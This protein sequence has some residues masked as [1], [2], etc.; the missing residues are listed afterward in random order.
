MRDDESDDAALD[1]VLL[2]RALEPELEV[3]P[4][5]AGHLHAEDARAAAAGSARLAALGELAGQLADPGRGVD[6]LPEV[7]ARRNLGQ[8]ELDR[9]GPGSDLASRTLACHIV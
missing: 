3:V 7:A 5:V 9:S 1:R 6:E 8:F 2:P 4:A